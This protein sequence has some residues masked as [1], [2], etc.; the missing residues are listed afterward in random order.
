[1][2]GVCCDQE[3]CTIDGMVRIEPIPVD[4]LRLPKPTDPTVRIYEH[5]HPRAGG[6]SWVGVYP[7]RSE[8]SEP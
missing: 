6:C 5:L 8:G 3:G 1:M 2:K 7:V 4:L